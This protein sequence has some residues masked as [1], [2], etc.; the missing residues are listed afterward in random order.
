MLFEYLPVVDAPDESISEFVLRAK[1]EKEMHTKL[2]RLLDETDDSKVVCI[3]Y[4]G[5]RPDKPVP[6]AKFF[7]R[8]MI[9]DINIHYAYG[10]M[11]YDFSAYN[12]VARGRR[13]CNG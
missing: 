5:M 12:T 3:Y 13:T 7:V 8:V 9:E 6:V 4:I 2:Q 1:D 11:L 10:L